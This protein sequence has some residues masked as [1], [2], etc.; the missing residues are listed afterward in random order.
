MEEFKMSNKDF[1]FVTVLTDAFIG[2]D[3]VR[4]SREN[5]TEEEIKSALK[6][7]KERF[8]VD[9]EL[10]YFNENTFGIQISQEND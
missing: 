9:A 7:I 3:T 2:V 8:N 5:E 6:E 4:F 1:V 10:I